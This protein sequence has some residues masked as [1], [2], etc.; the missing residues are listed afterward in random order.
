MGLFSSANRY[1][2]RF[3]PNLGVYGTQA[4]RMGRSAPNPHSDP[5]YMR[6]RHILDTGRW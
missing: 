2:L 3:F 4:R 1:M 5:V 6:P